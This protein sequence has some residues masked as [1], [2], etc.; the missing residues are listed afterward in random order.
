MSASRDGAYRRRG[1]VMGLPRGVLVSIAAH[2]DEDLD[3]LTLANDLLDL[4]ATIPQ[5]ASILERVSVDDIPE[6]GATRLHWMLVLVREARAITT[7]EA[8]GALESAVPRR[9]RR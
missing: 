6:D 3:R 9:L 4:G 2:F 8:L 5:A 1:G 7:T